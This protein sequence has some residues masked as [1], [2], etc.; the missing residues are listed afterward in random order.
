MSSKKIYIVRHGQ[1]DYN[2]R[3]V[4]QGSGIDAPLNETG[5]KQ[6]AAFFEQN[7]HIPFDLVYYSGLI[8]TKQS[9]QP[10]LEMG[11]PGLSLPDLNE[12]SWGK[13][14][15]IP[16]DE[17]G[18]QHYQTMLNRWSEGQLDYR[19]E[20]GESPLEVSHRL[21]RAIDH[22]TGNGGENILVCMHGRAIRILMCLLLG[23]PLHEM[24]YFQHQNLCCYQLDYKGGDLYELIGYRGSP[25]HQ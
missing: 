16:M 19:I 20:G 18:H 6:A 22:I 23:K 9:I 1:T 3:G 4:V 10:F 13:Y 21:S 11:I 14:E 25:I 7:R 17:N 24:D 12:I 2:L 15:G 5:R 8:R